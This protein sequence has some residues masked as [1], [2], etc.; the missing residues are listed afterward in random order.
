MTRFEID[1]IKKMTPY[2][3]NPN[4]YDVK[5]DAN[6]SAFPISKEIKEAIAEAIVKD[7]FNIY[8]DPMAEKVCRKYAQLMEVDFENVVAGNGSD[9]LISVLTTA[10]LDH[11]DKVLYFTPDFSM[12][13]FYAETKGN[14]VI[15]VA[16]GEDMVLTPEMIIESA[17]QYAPK[18]IFFSNPCN[19][20]GIGLTREEVKQVLKAVDCLVVVDEAYMDYWDQSVIQDIKEFD[21]LIVL[22]TCSKAFALA[23]IRLGFAL[24][25]PDIIE[26]IKKVKSPYNVSQ[27]TQIAA[28]VV[29][30]QA[31]YVKR[32][33]L[34]TIDNRRYLYNKLKDLKNRCPNDLRIFKSGT[35]FLYMKSAKAADIVNALK[36]KSIII[37]DYGNSYIRISIG[38]KKQ[39]EQVYEVMEQILLG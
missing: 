15:R 39:V 8:P 18:M 20:T 11:D 4:V 38:T 32:D 27:L 29:F 34:T 21:N 9:E 7:G 24:A 13:G 14:E 35:N 31:D 10:F 17:K 33:L 19:P 22:K 5:L 3:A 28:Q 6:E 12:Y 30:E 36:D 25:Q 23:G 26:V 37:R 2:T 16:K 1:R